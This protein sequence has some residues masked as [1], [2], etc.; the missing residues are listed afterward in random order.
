LQ[1]DW[2]YTWT[3]LAEAPAANPDGI[4]IIANDQKKKKSLLGS[5]SNRRLLRIPDSEQRQVSNFPSIFLCPPDGLFWEKDI[6]TL[7]C[8][9]IAVLNIN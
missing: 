8:F 1:V 6:S 4:L 5:S 3:E 2:A 9:P 7:R